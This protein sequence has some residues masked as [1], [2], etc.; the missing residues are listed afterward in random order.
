MSFTSLR[1][2]TSSAFRRN[3]PTAAPALLLRG[4]AISCSISSDRMGMS[5]F[6]FRHGVGFCI[7]AGVGDYGGY[8]DYGQDGKDGDSED[9]HGG[10]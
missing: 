8:V 10:Q 4:G 1:L 6:P 7:A 5:V 2:C 3:L 9:V